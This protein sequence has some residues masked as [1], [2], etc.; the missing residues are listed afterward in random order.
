VFLT[1]Q[2]NAVGAITLIDT[3]LPEAPD[4]VTPTLNRMKAM[5]AATLPDDYSGSR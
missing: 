1:P 2:Q 3:I 5:I 4:Y